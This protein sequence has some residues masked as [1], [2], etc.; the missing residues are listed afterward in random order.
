MWV[1]RRALMVRPCH[2]ATG[3][4]V[5][6]LGASASGAG[7][8]HLEPPEGWQFRASPDVDVVGDEI[9]V[10]I[11]NID[12]EADALLYR[13]GV[14]QRIIDL[15]HRS[16]GLELSPDGGMLLVRRPAGEGDCHG[17]GGSLLG[18]DGTL[19]WE[20][21][22]D[23]YLS[24]GADGTSIVGW[25]RAGA[26]RSGTRVTILGLNGKPRLEH[27]A[28]EP[29][30]GVTAIRGGSRLVL[31]TAEALVGLERSADDPATLIEAWRRPHR[32]S[33]SALRVVGHDRF[34]TEGRFGR[35]DIIDGDGGE[36]FAYDPI[37]LG[38]GDADNPWALRTPAQGLAGD[39]LLLFDGSS[40]AHRIGSAGDRPTPVDIDARLPGDFERRPRL[41]RGHLVFDRTD[42]VVV[43]RLAPPRA[44]RIEGEKLE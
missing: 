14:R 7:D 16:D 40:L 31:S 37:S 27:D 6:M 34:I 17:G 13:R 1:G 20:I 36:I 42:R 43:R 25:P 15:P 35:F 33:T 5:V 26:C 38:G 8:V 29:V 21:Q 18:S 30:Y 9:V 11:S 2:V 44:S 41:I 19:L 23:L 28:G 32:F 4:L 10:Q 3:L 24:F 39:E 22:E 12:H